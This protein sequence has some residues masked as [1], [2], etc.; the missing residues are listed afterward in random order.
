VNGKSHTIIISIFLREIYI[1]F[2]EQLFWP[3]DTYG[4]W[5][6]LIAYFLWSSSCFLLGSLWKKFSCVG[7]ALRPPFFMEMVFRKN[8]YLIEGDGQILTGENWNG[9]ALGTNE[10]GFTKKGAKLFH[11]GSLSL[12]GLLIG[13]IRWCLLGLSYCDQVKRDR[14]PQATS[15][16]IWWDLIG[17]VA[18]SGIFSCFD[19]LLVFASQACFSGCP[20]GE[21]FRSA[22]WR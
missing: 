5:L 10:K 1:S 11:W 12:V 3:Q 17:L 20:L 4:Y 16:R 14:D 8:R 7:F 15:T 6:F 2:S 21:D 9:W 13:H 18:F 22:T 19:N